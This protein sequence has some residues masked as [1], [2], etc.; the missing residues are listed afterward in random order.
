M[1]FGKKIAHAASTSTSLC[2]AE[3]WLDYKQLKKLL[4]TFEASRDVSD[5]K[6]SEPKTNVAVSEIMKNQDEKNFFLF[7]RKEL[8]KVSNIFAELE[9]RALTQFLQ[10][11]HVIEAARI[12]RKSL[13]DQ[14]LNSIVQRLTV[15]HRHLVLLRNF[16]VLNYCGFTKILKKH[17]KVT[18]FQTRD[19]Y[20]LKMVNEQPFAYH[21]TLKKALEILAEEYEALK[22]GTVSIASRRHAVDEFAESIRA[23]QAKQ[24][25]DEEDNSGITQ[26]PQLKK[27]NLKPHISNAVRGRYNTNINNNKKNKGMANNVNISAA[28]QSSLN[29]RHRFAKPQ[30]SPTVSP[31]S[32]H[33]RKGIQHTIEYKGDRKEQLGAT[34]NK[35]GLQSQ[36]QFKN[37]VN[38]RPM[39]RPRTL[40]NHCG[41]QY[42]PLD[43]LSSLMQAAEMHAKL[44][45]QSSKLESKT[46]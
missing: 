8:T 40:L 11:L 32:M 25:N 12:E 22:S 36:P 42:R 3:C 9:R 14:H 20:M 27:N 10:M 30:V 15:V 1:K 38:T 6:S 2:K 34:T 7:L 18:G 4:K 45:T 13:V 24:L 17:D 35:L 31:T 39:K 46:A 44:D 29:K 16:A 21:T 37:V 33:S 26:Y 43:P 19:K 41:E 5:G 28:N 23:S